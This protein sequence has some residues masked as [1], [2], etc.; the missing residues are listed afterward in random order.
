MKLRMPKLSVTVIDWLSI[1]SPL[2]VTSS[3]TEPPRS[4]AE[5]CRPRLREWSRGAWE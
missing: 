5:H 3:I 1:T 4:E 2:P